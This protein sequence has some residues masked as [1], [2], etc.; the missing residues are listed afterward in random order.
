MLQTLPT[1]STE[2]DEITDDAIFL[3]ANESYRQWVSIDLSE[4]PFLNRYPDNVSAKLRQE[5]C[6]THAPDFSNE[7]VLVTAGSMELI[8]LVLRGFCRKGLLINEPSY[9][10]YETKALQSGLPV[11]KVLLRDDFSLNIDELRV[12]SKSADVLLLINPNNPTGSLVS[13]GEL[14]AIIDFFDGTIIIDEA[15]IEFAGMEHSLAQFALSH[16]NIIVFR[17]FSKAWGLAG[18]R[19]GYALAPPQIIMTLT[20][21]KNAYNVSTIAQNI[22]IQA[23]RQRDGLR[24]YVKDC[25]RQKDFLLSELRK[26]G[27]QTKDTHANFILVK[28]LGSHRLH[29]YLKDKGILV[30]HRGHQPL[31]EDTIRVTVGAS[32]EN[33]EL[34]ASIEEFLNA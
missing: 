28:V 16:P 12:H 26:H 27:V 5:I 3:D 8:D 1:Y 33:T 25:L 34:I 2:R 29:N 20:A 11:H 14:E 4:M 23:L 24:E 6:A 13:P 21:L 22:G 32:R 19:L 31:L 15:Y 30:R 18:I 17:S 7:Q 9:Q 10:V